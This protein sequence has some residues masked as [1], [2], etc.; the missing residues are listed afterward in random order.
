M[1]GR[2]SAVG[3]AKRK[4]RTAQGADQ[5]GGSNGTSGISADAEVCK[6]FLARA[7]PSP[8]SPVAQASG[9]PP[10]DETVAQASEGPP[11]GTNEGAGRGGVGGGR[12]VGGDRGAAGG[13]GVPARGLA[14]LDWPGWRSDGEG[15]PVKKRWKLTDRQLAVLRGVFCG[16]TYHEIGQSLGIAEDTVD[17]HFRVLKRDKLKVLDENDAMHLVYELIIELKVQ[18]ALQ[19]SS[20]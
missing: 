10:V 18:E 3:A 6:S 15:G 2:L 4:G 5:P 17:S 1:A 9:G 20:G 7:L 13:T 19:K 11:P 8:P 14:W 16:Q 12:R